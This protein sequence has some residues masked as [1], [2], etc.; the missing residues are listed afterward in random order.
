MLLLLE[1]AQLAFLRLVLELLKPQLALVLLEL[2]LR[3]LQELLR[4]ELLEL[5][6]AALRQLVDRQLVLPERQEFVVAALGLLPVLELRNL[7]LLEK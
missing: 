5:Q 6:L 1:L 3:V 2:L 7:A 4:L